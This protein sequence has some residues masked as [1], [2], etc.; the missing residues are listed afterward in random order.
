MICNKRAF[1]VPTATGQLLPFFHHRDLKVPLDKV[2][3]ND[4]VSLEKLLKYFQCSRGHPP[5]LLRMLVSTGIAEWYFTI[6]VSDAADHFCNR[7]T[8][9][10][11][12]R[13]LPVISGS[14]IL[15]KVCLSTLV[16]SEKE[17]VDCAN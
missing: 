5:L 17:K 6:Y 16:K 1:S 11:R 15:D 8:Y 10:P 14:D 2:M 12:R 3:G 4:F 13:F 9:V 7:G